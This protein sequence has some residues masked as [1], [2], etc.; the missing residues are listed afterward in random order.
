MHGVDRKLMFA[1][2]SAAGDYHLKLVDLV[3]VGFYRVIRRVLREER[4]GMIEH[5]FGGLDK[6]RAPAVES[7]GHHAAFPAGYYVVVR[8]ELR[9]GRILVQ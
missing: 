6:L 3:K 2:C 9:H 7:A 8:S 5:A 4:H 1:Q